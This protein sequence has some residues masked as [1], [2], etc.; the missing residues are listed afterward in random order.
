ME[1]RYSKK[2][3]KTLTPAT[4]PKPS[5]PKPTERKLKPM[6]VLIR[7]KR[8]E[9]KQYMN[10]SNLSESVKTSFLKGVKLDTNVNALKRKIQTTI[11]NLKTQTSRRGKLRTELKV[12]LNTLDLTNDVKRQSYRKCW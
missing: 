10:T 3:D 7:K 8:D 5:R 2:I 6:R 4:V 9:I 1:P 12:Y 11:Q